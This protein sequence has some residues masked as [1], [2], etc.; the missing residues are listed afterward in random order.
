MSTP[1]PMRGRPGRAAELRQTGD[2]L[3]RTLNLKLGEVLRLC[4][5]LE[6]PDC[7]VH[8]GL[9]HVVNPAPGEH[10]DRHRHPFTE[11]SLVTDATVEYFADTAWQRVAPGQVVLIPADL[12][13]A[14][15]NSSRAAA[16]LH[17]FML[18]IAP[19]EAAP[20]SLAL[21]LNAAARELRYHFAPGPDA[22]PLVHLLERLAVAPA[23][24]ATAAAA[25]A[26]QALLALL[27][28]RVRGAVA[29]LVAAARLPAPS[30]ATQ[31][32]LRARSHILRQLEHGITAATAA[33]ELGVSLRHLNRVFAAAHLL[34]CGQ[35]ILTQQLERAKHLLREPGQSVKEV[36][37]TCGFSQPAYFCRIFRKHLGTS[38]G[39]WSKFGNR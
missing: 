29:A 39:A 10:T 1:A 26:V 2:P 24:Y 8:P 20:D 13:H 37:L 14:W 27:L 22:L 38:P 5:M 3:T 9:Y 4:P 35:F 6:L 17:G 25:G 23:S 11:M 12:P 32:Q 19:R 30:A 31:L 28:D 18:D 21:H 7:T 36:A 16:T 34:S 15:R 33:R